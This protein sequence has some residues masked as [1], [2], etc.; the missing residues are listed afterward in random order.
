MAVRIAL[1]QTRLRILSFTQNG[2][3]LG[4]PCSSWDLHLKIDVVSCCSLFRT[5]SMQ[6]PKH[7]PITGLESHTRFMLCPYSPRVQAV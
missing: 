7:E 2:I 5:S 4:L 6:Y 1:C 3:H